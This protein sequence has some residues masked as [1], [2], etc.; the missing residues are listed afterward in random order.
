[1]LDITL[2]RLH[3][4]GDEHERGKFVHLRGLITAA[5]SIALMVSP[6][7]A[8]ANGPPAKTVSLADEARP[9]AETV[10][11]MQLGNRELWV[12]LGIIVAG[13]VACL[14]WCG[15]SKRDRPVSP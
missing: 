15:G 3:S 10:S 11:G 9:A 1:M 12:V 7:L 8:A 6:S 5:A 14:I 2:S 4:Y 13:G